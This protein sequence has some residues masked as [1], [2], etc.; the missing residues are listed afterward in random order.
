MKDVSELGRIVKDLN[1][2]RYNDIPD[3][4]LGRIWKAQYPGQYDDFVEVL[5]MRYEPSQPSYHLDYLVAE[6]DELSGI[7]RNDRGRLSSWWQR[8]KAGS[9][10]K[11]LTALNAEM[12]GIIDVIHRRAEAHGLEWRHKVGMEMELLLHRNQA[13]ILEIATA[14][15]MDV[16]TYQQKI[17]MQLE[18]D[19]EILLMHE[20]SH[21]RMTE[22]EREAELEQ[23]KLSHEYSEKAKYAVL[24]KLL[25]S[26]EELKRLK[27]NKA[28][29][30]E[31]KAAKEHIVELEQLWLTTFSKK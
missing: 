14:Q 7:Y 21:I 13:A 27:G 20:Q 1:P 8:G 26:K 28:S 17:L 24:S 30:L 16:S 11:L 12:V 22:R 10:A 25:D 4:E 29:R 5:P 6:L 15:G 31:L 23:F 3:D 19:K 9:R 2:G 18:V